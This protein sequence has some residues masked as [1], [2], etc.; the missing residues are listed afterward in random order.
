MVNVDLAIK[1][2][3]KTLRLGTNMEDVINELTDLSRSFAHDYNFED[4]NE[5][6]HQINVE[7]KKDKIMF[8]LV[9]M[10]IPEE[11]SN[12]II[13]AKRI[14]DELEEIHVHSMKLIFIAK[15]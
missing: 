8:N 2:Q 5:Y 15:N 1:Q 11:E 7:N 14:S 13:K 9:A 6:W 12:Y 3:E 10:K 4:L